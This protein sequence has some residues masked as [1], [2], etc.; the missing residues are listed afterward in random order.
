MK[1]FLHV[2]LLLFLTNT[3]FAQQQYTFTNYTQEQGL[4]S[5]T[6]IE[7]HKDTTGYLWVTS[8]EGVARFDGYNFK[9]FRHNPDDSTSLPN[10]IAR[11]ATLSDRGDIYILTDAKI[12]LYDPG[13]LSFKSSYIFGDTAFLPL[14]GTVYDSRIKFFSL[15]DDKENYY[16]TSQGKL[17]KIGKSK[18]DYYTLPEKDPQFYLHVTTDFVNRAILFVRD[19]RTAWF[20]DCTKKNKIQKI[21]FL[22]SSGEPDTAEI[23]NCI[24]IK[25]E[26]AF[27]AIGKN[28][29]YRYNQKLNCFVRQFNLPIFKKLK[30]D[31][32]Y[33]LSVSDKYLFTFSNNGELYKLNINDGKE[34]T[35]YLNKKIPENELKERF[36]TELCM[37]ED[38][39]L[40]LSSRG[41][42]LFRFDPEQ[43]Q[44][45]QFVHEPNNSN[46]LPSNAADYVL[47]DK[48]G[49]IW[50][51]CYGYGLVKMEMVNPVLKRAIPFLKKDKI[52]SG[53]SN[54]NVRTF[55]ETDNG[56]L[57]GTFKGLYSFDTRT[58]EYSLIN[59]LSSPDSSEDV[60][61]GTLAKDHSDNLWIGSWEGN[62][63]IVNN[64][65]K[66]QIT[67]NVPMPKGFYEKIWYR[68]LYYDSKNTMWISTFHGG[69]YSVKVNEINFENPS[70][71]KF[72]S[73][74]K[75]DKDTLSIS[76]NTVFAFIEDADGVIWAGT[77]TGLCKFNSVTKKWT[78]YFNIP[79]DP[80]SLHN[81][82]VRSFAID[83]K[84]ILWIGT[85][86][87]GLNRYNKAENNF[88]HFTMENGLPND[89]I[90][91]LTCD[92]NGMLWLGTNHGL[93][94][95][96]PVD[97]SCKNFNEK[98]GIQNYE[99]NTGAALK[100]KNGTLLIGGVAGYNIIDPN[101]IESKKI[102]TPVVISSFKV[103]DKET[104][105]GNGH[106]ILNYR[107]NSFSFEFAA[108]SFI[109]N[110]ENHY[111]YMLE[112]VDQDWVFS[113]TRRYVT[114]SQ[115]KPGTYTFKVKAA[116]HYGV[117]NE[118][119]TQMQITIAS[120]WWQKTWFIILCV[121]V[122]IAIIYFINK[123][124]EN[125]KKQLEAVR[126]RISRDLHDDMGSTL[127]SI[128][129]MSEIV[130]MKSKSDI[131]QESSPFIEKIGNA[132]REMIEKM[133][134]IVW[135]VNPQNDQFE[136][137]IHHMRAFGGELLAGKDIA[138]HFI[139]DNS[140][141]NIKLSM[142]ARKSFFLIYKEALNNAFKYSGAKNVT[143][144]IS[145]TNHTLHLIIEDDG[146][147]FNTKESRLRTGGNGLKNMNTRAVEMNGNILIKSE[148]DHGT[149]VS[150]T[151][152]LK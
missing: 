13:T 94:R 82:N 142:E 108:L 63:R 66:K 125:R 111:A 36:I 107:E 4:P 78:R 62:L 9:V 2:I 99:Y 58:N 45:D 118:K 55:L 113:N 74:F 85:N 46:S 130:S 129:V 51:T 147:G 69:T 29:L 14:T 115:L 48:N 77:E 117:W 88:S 150:L 132:S 106:V 116:N 71:V 134:D 93:C 141:N 37:D 102:S 105:P 133:N 143:I 22:N 81:N 84:G 131:R 64:R 95:F 124:E 3:S 96:N 137:I 17:L 11:Y 12:Q 75:D 101:K 73:Y 40:W 59:Y 136:N 50:A 138:L 34:K 151:V 21:N 83:K 7:I 122:S 135:A 23:N 86:G 20:F 52:T 103:F 19:S 18:V 112:G 68:Q 10:N 53:G 121:L 120:P 128:S 32:Y 90:Y 57:I 30:E 126:S 98:D 152:N 119:G 97:Y 8:E 15:A 28:G 26:D 5:G 148:K 146:R 76:S 109:R 104:P 16:A 38:H 110:Q 1:I 89:A 25:G 39:K 60:V 127:Q 140:I 35:F 31:I 61:I 100:L 6:I 27:F 42:G 65:L 144:K 80:Y 33:F 24:Y 92:N 44:W 72:D 56:Y 145:K 139:T 87:G 79:G 41:M 67:L 149:T 70:L 43:E 49:V 114:Y 91:N 123:Y 47:P 54:E